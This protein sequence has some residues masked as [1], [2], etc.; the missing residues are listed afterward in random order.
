MPVF[1]SSIPNTTEEDLKIA[2]G[3]VNESINANGSICKLKKI[4]SAHYPDSELYYFNRGRDSIHFFLQNLNLQ[5]GDEIILQGFTCIAVVAPI[6]WAKC[7]PIY[8]DISRDTFNMN[9]DELK[10]KISQKTRVI[11]VQHTFGNIANIKRIRDIVNEENSNRVEG[12]KI[13]ILED[14]AHLLDFNNNE[15]GKYSD[16][17][18]FSFA[19]DKSISSTQGSLIAI[20][21]SNTLREKFKN[22]YE[23]V[24]N[25]SPEE[26]LYNAKYILYWDR[27]KR[28]YFTKIISSRVTVGKILLIWYRFVGKIRKQASADSGRYNGI[29][30]MSE[31]QARLLLA[32]LNSLGSFNQ[33]RI[34]I[35]LIYGKKFGG[36]MLRYPILVK[37][38]MELKGK[39]RDIGIISGSWYSTPVFPIS[40]DCLKSIGYKIGD[41]PEV[42]FCSKHIV[43][44]PTNIEVNKDS[45]REI[46][47]VVNR[48]AKF[49]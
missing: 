33:N 22:S 12:E 16:A 25:L 42:E 28:Y 34:S 27:I 4:F 46:M 30:K 36:T 26:A 3:I 7:I 35:S 24:P 2:Q 38:P 20:K 39:L 48:Y 8:T 49:I 10:E 19:Q 18:L 17:F 29:H 31:T 21:K 40:W 11:I 44:L 9:I 23:H 37:N 14:C 41:C 6:L 15:I 5:S 32:Q 47:E 45:A 13:Y 43:N 1:I